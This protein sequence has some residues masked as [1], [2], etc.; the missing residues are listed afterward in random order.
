MKHMKA[1]VWVAVFAQIDIKN[2]TIHILDGAG[3][4][5]EIQVVIGEG[6]LTYTE[7]REMEYN[8]DRGII[9]EVRLG[10]QVPMDVRL[11]FRWDYI[12]G[13]LGTGDPPSVE[14]FLKRKNSA[15]AFVS[16]DS[17][18]CRPFAVDLEIRNVPLPTTCGDK[19]TITLP[20][21]RYEQLDHD[22]R[23]GTVAVSGR[24]NAQEATVV[25][26]VQP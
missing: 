5:N 9:D 15:A 2:A 1:S 23:A 18:A 20:D 4:P 24:S 12:Q 7:R 17:D 19:E 8:L 25:R 26:A 21:F 3:T 16:T 14:D 13:T 6:N 10:D 11:D 22:L